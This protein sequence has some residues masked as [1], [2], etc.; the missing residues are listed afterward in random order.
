M[1]RGSRGRKRERERL[2][3]SIYREREILKFSSGANKWGLQTK[4]TRHLTVKFVFFSLIIRVLPASDLS[5]T[6]FAL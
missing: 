2:K 6:K 3:M 5:I 4:D 1:E